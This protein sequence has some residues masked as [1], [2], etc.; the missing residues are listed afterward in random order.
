MVLL[1]KKAIGRPNRPELGGIDSSTPANTYVM[2]LMAWEAG[3][4][5]NLLRQVVYEGLREAASRGWEAVAAPPDKTTA[6][7]RR[8]PP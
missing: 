3:T 1:R 8:P 5:D 2:W 7:V 4:E 6:E